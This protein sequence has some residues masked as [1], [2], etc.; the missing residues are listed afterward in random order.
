MLG[1]LDI[2]QSVI[3]PKQGLFIFGGFHTDPAILWSQKL[4][5]ISGPWTSGPD[6]YQKMN[7][8][9]HCIVQVYRVLCLIL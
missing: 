4:A 1:P 5:T 3:V 9:N 2:A 8:Q 7:V 6:L